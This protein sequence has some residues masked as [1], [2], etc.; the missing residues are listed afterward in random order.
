MW[1]KDRGIYVFV[2]TQPKIRSY[3]DNFRHLHLLGRIRIS[4]LY[5]L[6]TVQLADSRTFFL[7]L[8]VLLP[9][10]PFRG[11]RG[12]VLLNGVEKISMINL[13]RYPILLG[14]RHKQDMGWRERKKVTHHAT[15]PHNR[16]SLWLPLSYH[17]KEK[18]VSVPTRCLQNYSIIPTFL[19][20]HWQFH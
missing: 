6:Y 7:N 19:V 14:S 18:P 20:L 2:V 13:R 8:I 3:G 17:Q 16:Y 1:M 15:F 5:C 9:D 11:N 10:V 12:S 4:I